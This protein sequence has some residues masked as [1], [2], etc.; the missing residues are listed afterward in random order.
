M[1]GRKGFT[2]GTV[3]TPEHVFDVLDEEAAKISNV[4]IDRDVMQRPAA[5]FYVNISLPYISHEVEPAGMF[6]VPFIL[7]PPQD[8]FEVGQDLDS[9]PVPAFATNQPRIKLRSISF[10][11]DQRAEPAA[12]T[13]HLWQ[14]SGES[15]N[16]GQPP[17]FP[18][19][20]TLGWFGLS[21]EQGKLNF[22]DVGRLNINLAI[23]EKGQEFFGDEYPYRPDREVWS[24]SIP[25]SAYAGQ[26]LRANPFIQSDID[27][28]VSPFKT[29]V[30]AVSCPGLD[31]R[32]EGPF[33]GYPRGRFLVLPS[34]EISIRFS[35]D[36]M[37][38]DVG[39]SIAG[40]DV[41]NMPRRGGAG[42]N[43][44]GA[45]TGPSVLIDTPVVGA[46]IEADSTY[47]VE[48]NIARID[49]EFVK[50]FQGGYNAYADTPPTES[51]ADDAAYEVIAIPLFSN[52]AHGGIT[53][54]IAFSNTWPYLAQDSSLGSLHDN[55][56][57]F[58]RR[59][60]PVRHS[61]TIQHVFLAWNWT[62]WRPLNVGNEA[63]GYPGGTPDP[64]YGTGP[65]IALLDDYAWMVVPSQDIALSIGVGIGTGSAADN[66]E[67][68][69]VASLGLSDP[70]NFAAI[71]PEMRGWGEGSTL[72]DR[73]LTTGNSVPTGAVGNS[74]NPA[75][76]A[77]ARWN[78][79]LHSVPLVGASGVGYYPQGA[80]IFMGPG[81]TN[82][83]IRS[84]APNVP[85]APAPTMGAEQ[86]LEVRGAMWT[87]DTT[88]AVQ[89]RIA[90]AQT[91]YAPHQ[92][93]DLQSILVGY[94]GCYVYIICKK[95]LTR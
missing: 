32:H 4:E 52:S 69:Q 89:G 23:Y 48:D 31:D 72:V 81:W 22:E 86:W 53:G 14:F 5:P 47:G 19:D 27:V 45:K 34:V 74:G 93:K 33:P 15:T 88:P 41:Q 70:N 57:V 91:Q 29:Y 78:W 55:Q 79:E 50:K 26:H 39:A 65:P 92:V 21:S 6:T 30:F 49:D 62:P 17:P 67:Y 64:F 16:P 63:D 83:K 28:L 8:T 87:T 37:P 59:I 36:L 18:T 46:V 25:A 11:F 2:R 60:I 44:Y 73:I 13:S 76:D 54:K 20:L 68:A 51:V 80:P 24:A 75:T 40:N 56:A 66:F 9:N 42:D 61:Y 43:Q 90:M 7:P 1:S 84:N 38:R 71:S 10:S 85:A 35:S 82:T 94:G 77:D 12:I 58:D 3:L 95:H